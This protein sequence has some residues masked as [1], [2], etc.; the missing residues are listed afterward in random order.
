MGRKKATGGQLAYETTWVHQLSLVLI[1]ADSER[2]GESKR[3]GWGHCQI[4][5]YSE[6]FKLS[7]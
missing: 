1:S 4:G 6:H 2:E 3:W 7:K 5:S